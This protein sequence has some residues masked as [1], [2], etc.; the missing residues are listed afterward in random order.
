MNEDL[1]GEAA[2]MR[3]EIARLNAEVLS[4][5]SELA[6]L[7]QARAAQHAHAGSLTACLARLC[8]ADQSA[9]AVWGH[10]GAL[11]GRRLSLCAQLCR[12][13]PSLPAKR[14]DIAC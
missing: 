4:F 1:S 14:H 7:Q 13:V 9:H 3:T 8:Y 5:K 2:A 10:A 12:H 11:H 6:L